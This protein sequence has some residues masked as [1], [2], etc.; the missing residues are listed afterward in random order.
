MTKYKDKSTYVL[1]PTRT[2]RL[3]S[4]FVGRLL[5]LQAPLNSWRQVAFAAGMEVAEAYNVLVATALKSEARYFLTLEDDMMVE[6]RHLINLIDSIGDYDAVGA[7]YFL[8]DD[9]KTPVAFGEGLLPI[10]VQTGQKGVVA[11]CG[12]GFGCTLWKR[13]VFEG[14]QAPWFETVDTPTKRRTHDLDFAE[15]I[16]LHGFRVAVNLDVDVGHM[17][18]ETGEIF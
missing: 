7:L 8:K 10:E 6:P 3:E 15:R 11:C 12:L 2:G 16:A 1:V 17:D 14:L 5:T 9:S 4:R 13:E 18:Y